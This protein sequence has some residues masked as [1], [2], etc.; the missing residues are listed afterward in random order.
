MSLQINHHVHVSGH[1]MLTNKTDLPLNELYQYLIEIN[2]L[3]KYI[4]L[5]I[6]Y[7]NRIWNGV[8]NEQ[9]KLVCILVD[10]PKLT[11]D[12]CKAFHQVIQKTVGFIEKSLSKKLKI[13]RLKYAS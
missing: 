3:W 6:K 9:H 1:H 12:W 2:H 13:N 10:Y 11:L 5:V 8:Y 7:R 4:G